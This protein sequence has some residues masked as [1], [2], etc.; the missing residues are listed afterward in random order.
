[1]DRKSKFFI[2]NRCNNLNLSLTFSGEIPTCCGREMENIAPHTEGEGTEKHLPRVRVSG[3]LVTVSVADTPHPMT[4]EH[5]I[6]WIYLVTREGDARKHLI[7]E[8]S[9]ERTFAL[10]EGD[11]PV[12]AYAYCNRHGLWKTQINKGK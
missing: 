9:P 6:G 7:A 12:A 8:D 10:T 1:M 4:E 2:C 5:N 3:S 11:I